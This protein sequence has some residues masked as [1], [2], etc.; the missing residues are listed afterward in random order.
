[1]RKFYLVGAI[2]LSFSQLFISNSAQSAQSHNHHDSVAS[3]DTHTEHDQTPALTLSTVQQQL[4]KI[5]V[6]A[7]KKHKPSQKLYA[8]G[9]LKENGYTSYVV[10]P[11][12]DSVIVTRHTTLGERV[13]VGDKLITL[14]SETMAQAQADYMVSAS[15]W[16]RLEN[17]TD[18]SLSDSQ[19]VQA[20]TRYLA[21]MGR[22]TA[23]GLSSHAISQLDEQSNIELGQYSLYAQIAGIVLQDD[24]A[25]GQRVSTGQ[26]LMRLA[27]EQNLW[28]EARLSV[29]DSQQ[30]SQQ[31]QVV[32]EYQGRAYP[33]KVI[34]ESHT[35]DPVTRTRNVRL[36]VSNQDHQLHA[37]MFVNVHFLLP[38]QQPIVTVP[39]TALVR[40]TDGDWQV[41]VTDE[42]NQFEAVQVQRGRAFGEQ[43]EVIG[44]PEGTHVVTQ[45]AFFI[46]SQLA[47]SSFDPH[48][49]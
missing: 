35:I 2:C 11:R 5:H 21:S 6:T 34:Q 1:M 25:Q 28:V 45:G 3:A 9:E 32:V 48:N 26:T 19:R 38:T 42:T 30:I 16:K 46:S 4:A 41:F 24:F 10:S 31:S 33:A 17:L 27:D 49:H 12:T 29:N 23:L 8:P 37:G 40:S 39:E 14:Y 20:K 43:I 18:Q 22:L 13:K 44:I 36:Q 47:K 7:L 15:E